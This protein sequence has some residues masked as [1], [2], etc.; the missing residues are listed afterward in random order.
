M[1]KTKKEKIRLVFIS[2]VI[3]GLIVSLVSSVG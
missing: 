2:L 3:V 1:K